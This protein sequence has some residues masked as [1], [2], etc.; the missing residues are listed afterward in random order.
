MVTK[1]EGQGDKNDIILLVIYFLQVTRERGE[2]GE[3]KY[4]SRGNR[5]NDTKV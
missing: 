3:K 5:D 1:L 4:K 2:R